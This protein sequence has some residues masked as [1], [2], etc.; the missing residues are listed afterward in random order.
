MDA[1]PRNQRL[2]W[3]RLNRGWSHAELAVQLSRS[4]Q[5]HGDPASGL[6]ANTVR[7]WETGARR[8]EPRYR[9]HLVLV[10]DQSAEDLGLLTPD[11]LGSRPDATMEPMAQQ[12]SR[13]AFIAGTAGL[14]LTALLPGNGLA[15]AA[16]LPNRPE[17]DDGRRAHSAACHLRATEQLEQ[18]YWSS[19]AHALYDAAIANTRLGMSLPV[20]ATQ[21]REL[22]S[23]TARSALLAG[24]LAFFDLGAPA[25]S[26]GCLAAAARLAAE[27]GDHLLAAVTYGHLAFLPGFAGDHRSANEALEVA[28]SHARYG[29]G[30]RTRSWL[31]C[32]RS[33]L[34]LRA[35]ETRRGL[36]QIR[37]AE[38]ALTAT[39]GHDPTWVDF[40]DA[41]RLAGFAGY[42]L[43]ATDRPDDA[44]DT[45]RLALDTL[46]PS[47]SKQRTVLLFD[48]AVAHA[49]GGSPEV[50][51]EQATRA[52]QSLASNDYATAH[53]RLPRLRSVLGTSPE[54]GHLDERIRE[55]LPAA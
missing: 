36:D 44:L 16:S 47:A 27:S 1:H 49:A 32:V 21:R 14:G 6:D 43:L 31:H 38:T 24:R 2:A 7:R 4:I 29:A 13:Q 48:L 30:P 10:F 51:V 23:S 35:G 39:T 45:F 34:A 25:S 55:L 11:E 5:A 19:P 28:T 37:Q 3:A 46:D 40:Y 17:D 33:E 15:A 22:A 52:L 41:S 50:A 18:L 54:G 42:A 53:D 8:P 9:K 20:P 12:I 26:E